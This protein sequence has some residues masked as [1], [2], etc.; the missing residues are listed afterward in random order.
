MHHIFILHALRALLAGSVLLIIAI[1]TRRPVP[2]T[3]QTWL[4]LAG[5]GL[6]ATTMAFLG[7]IHASEFISPGLAT[8]IA[9]T[10]PIFAA[11]FGYFILNEHLSFQSKIGVFTGFSGIV[12]IAL[13]GINMSGD[14]FIIGLVYLIFAAFGITFSNIIIRQIADNVD[15]IMAMAIQLLIGAIPLI[16]M[17]IYLEDTSDIKW[18]KEFLS[19]LLVLSIGGTALAYWLWCKI[20]ATIELA[21]ANVFTYLVPVL[22]LMM[23][24]YFYDEKFSIQ[25]L[26]GIS[27]TLISI[28]LVNSKKTKN[29]TGKRT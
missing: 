28:V 2:K 29:E 24:V 8:V 22:G 3:M 9:N 14:M 16:F 1:I 6:G 11:I 23:G 5:I 25:T 10:Q 19:S 7:M 4:K 26:M 15:A 20:L 13:P 21:R 17:A 18:T 12:V 27:L